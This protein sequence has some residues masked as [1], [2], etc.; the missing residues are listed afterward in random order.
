MSR[1]KK[2]RKLKVALKGWDKTQKNPIIKR[3]E[4]QKHLEDHQLEM[5]GQ[6]TTQEILE[7]EDH[8][9]RTWHQAC[10]E[11]ERYWKHKSR[12]LWL[13]AGDKNTSYFHKQVEAR[14]QFKT[15]IEIHVQDQVISYFE[16]IKM[17]TVEAFESLYKETQTTLLDSNAY[18]L[19]LVSIAIQ[20]DANNKLLVEVNL[21][22]IKE[23]LNQMNLD[24]ASRPDDFTAR[25]Y[26][27]FWDIIKIDLFKLVQKSQKCSKIG[28]RTNL[29]FLALILKEKGAISFGRFRP[30]SLCNTSYKLITKIIANRIKKNLPAIIPKNQGGFIKG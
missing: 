27:S 15:I 12:S 18:P 3:Q 8:L 9:Q 30:I 22:E 4:A 10:R 1:K 13:K 25:F 7:N 24:K 14:K 5:E 21:Q 28:G 20:E 26:Q 19:S 16:G 23:A 2:H 6:E 17:A 29:S 11:E